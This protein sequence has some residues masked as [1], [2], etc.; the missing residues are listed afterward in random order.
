MDN[1]KQEYYST[2][3]KKRRVLPPPSFGI[4]TQ[5]I[6]LVSI[7]SSHLR[8]RDP[9]SRAA[10]IAERIIKSALFVNHLTTDCSLLGNFAGFQNTAV[11]VSALRNNTTGSPNVA[12][13]QDTCANN[14]VTTD[15]TGVGYQALL[16][17]HVNGSTAFGF[18]ALLNNTTGSSTS[19]IGA[20]DTDAL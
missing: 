15:N 6:P 20:A 12:V 9:Q 18:Q 1:K 2:R 19:A 3:L 17:N 14:G 7:G 13:G 8:L 4:M 16:H 5:L 10:H 11:G